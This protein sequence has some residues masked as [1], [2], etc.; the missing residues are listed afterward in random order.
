MN[1]SHDISD[2]DSISDEASAIVYTETINSEPSNIAP[3]YFKNAF[4]DMNKSGHKDSSIE[5][6]KRISNISEVQQSM[7]SEVASNLGEVPD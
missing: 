4:N 1:N 2:I 6:E 3:D 5:F 7:I